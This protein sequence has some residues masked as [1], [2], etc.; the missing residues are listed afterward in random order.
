MKTVVRDILNIYVQPNGGGV[1]I[2]NA[3]VYAAATVEDALP[4]VVYILLRREPSVLQAPVAVGSKMRSNDENSQ[5]KRKF[6]SD[7]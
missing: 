4:G 3:L 5:M 7:V 2:A 1:D 6:E